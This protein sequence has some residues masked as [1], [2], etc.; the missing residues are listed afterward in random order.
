MIRKK[1]L[2][3]FS[4]LAVIVVL[5]SAATALYLSGDGDVL[6]QE[7][8][9]LLEEFDK[10]ELAALQR[11]SVLSDSMS[12]HSSSGRLK[13]DLNR[14]TGKIR[15][16]RTKLEEMEEKLSMDMMKLLRRNAEDYRSRLNDV[17]QVI[18]EKIRTKEVALITTADVEEEFTEKSAYV[19]D[20]NYLKLDELERIMSE[21]QRV[22]DIKNQKIRSFDQEIEM[23]ESELNV[24][25]RQVEVLKDKVDNYYEYRNKDYKESF[26]M[27]GY[28]N[29]GTKDFTSYELGM[30]GVGPKGLEYI[31]VEFL[32]PDDYL[33]TK[34]LQIEI[35]DMM[36]NQHVGYKNKVKDRWVS[37][38]VPVKSKLKQGTYFITIKV[39]D[40]LLF[41]RKFLIDKP[42]RS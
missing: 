11:V 7:K 19:K 27:A 38:E 16:S 9:S 34:P 15:S 13:K 29:T 28:V 12:Q 39:G 5:T 10:L 21:S 32:T 3:L 37:Y 31:K 22:I 14:I 24:L 25:R 42:V 4:F 6:E 33:T 23:K 18:D 17:S 2:I 1:N 35:Y 26:H 30:K 8:E 20:G 41:N 40:E 36:G